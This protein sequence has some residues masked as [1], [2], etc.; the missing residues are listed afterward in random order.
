MNFNF[1]NQPIKI[2]AMYI[3][4]KENQNLLLIRVKKK[5]I[6]RIAFNLLMQ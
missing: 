3:R 6:L 1:K 4:K 2:Q 5:A